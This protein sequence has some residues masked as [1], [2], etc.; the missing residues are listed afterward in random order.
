MLMSDGKLKE[1]AALST[2]DSFLL[3]LRLQEIMDGMGHMYGRE[4]SRSDQPESPNIQIII[5]SL[6]NSLFSIDF[7]L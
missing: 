7:W 6:K 3:Q 1:L 5:S 4:P 2:G